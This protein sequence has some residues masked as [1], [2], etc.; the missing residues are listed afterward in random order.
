MVAIISLSYM[1]ILSNS[2]VEDRDSHLG[3]EAPKARPKD[4]VKDVVRV[5]TH[6]REHLAIDLNDIKFHRKPASAREI[7]G[8]QV[9]RNL[10]AINSATHQKHGIRSAVVGTTAIIL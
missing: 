3:E 6:I 1:P 5:E 7:C 8:G 10:S 2:K 9:T 4:A